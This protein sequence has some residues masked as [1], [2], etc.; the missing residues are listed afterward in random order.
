VVLETSFREEFVNK[1]FTPIFKNGVSHSNLDNI[2][3]SCKVLY[4]N[5]DSFANKKGEIL[6]RIE[7]SK[8]DIIG[9]SEI[10]AKNE[11]HRISDAEYAI[12]TYDMFLNKNA[13]RGVVLHVKK[14]LNAR[15]CETFDDSKF[16]ESVWCTF[17][18]AN[19]ENVL[20]GCIYRSPNSLKENNEYLFEL[21]K[22]KEMN[23]Y[24]K[25]CILGDFNFPKA[26]W[27]SLRRGDGGDDI[28]ECV[29]DAFLWQKVKLPTRRRI[30]QRPTLDD[31]VL[32]NEEGLSS[33][34]EHQDPFGKSDH[35]VLVFQLYVSKIKI[36][37]TNKQK[38]DLNKGDYV[39]MRMN[40][41]DINWQEYTDLDVLE[42][43]DTIKSKVHTVMNECIPKVACGPGNRT[44]P[45]WMTPK[46]FK[47]IKKKYRLY[48]RYLSTKQG[49]DYTKYIKE[50]NECN[51]LLKKERKK[52]EK[53]IAKNCK[54][55]VKGFWKY[56]K[57]NTKSNSGVSSL[58]NDQGNIIVNDAEKAEVLNSFFASV[59]TNENL[60]NIPDLPPGS[61]SEG[62]TLSDILITN[63]AV[64]NK[65]KSLD[66]N[67]AQGPDQI[68]ARV[69]KELS[70]ELAF[71]LTVLFNKSIA[72]G[73]VPDEWKTAEVTAIFKKGS[74]S[75]PGN[76]RP[77]SLTCITGKVLEAIVRDSIV[78]YFNQYG[79]Y[80]ECQHG[81]RNKRSCMSQLLQV[82]ERLTLAFDESTPVD[83]VYLDFRKAFD[84]VPHERLVLKLEAYGI[85]GRI[86][87]WVKSFLSDRSQ[88]VRVN[89]KW[90]STG[91]YFRTY[92]IYYIYKRLA[93][94]Y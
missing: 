50:R 61:W 18:S 4:S 1:D 48:R 59:F 21:L 6:A 67:K 44:K 87:G 23:D 77:V 57:E 94:R 91:E 26:S 78:D 12:P 5:V 73:I 82:M 89:E 11:M 7:E 86:S 39:K 36:E 85:T 70:R 19:D 51:K 53:L 58:K 35:E 74:R 13:K 52:Y 9:L 20:V 38:F 69:L 79:F 66:S 37:K 80:S 65:L 49:A 81:F 40:F 93:K 33:D 41:N 88:R 28:V 63:L 22:R 15:E 16:E 29:R 64:E 45:I 3:D 27:D 31:L 60:D 43:W 42:L 68:P 32:V 84:T 71:P 17:T 55:N 75:D 25:I 72:T 62:I 76:Y 24:D 92:F 47:R 14:E 8:P 46:A 90:N 2:P 54:M 83:V 34:I 10:H 56:V 30:D